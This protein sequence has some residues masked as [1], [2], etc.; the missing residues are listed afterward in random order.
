LNRSLPVVFLALL[1]ACCIFAGAC[2]QSQ[3]SAAGTPK[4]AVLDLLA[5]LKKNDYGAVYDMLTSKDQKQVSRKEWIDANSK[6]PSSVA[7][8][9]KQ[10]TWTVTGEDIK[11]NTAT[12]TVKLSQGAQSE[13][14][15]FGLVKEG[16]AWKVSLPDSGGANQ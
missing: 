5:A 3:T 7:E 10:L 6:A 16:K 15:T 1:L 9:N 2:G 8:G 4:Q 14:V 12:L 13:D 11:G